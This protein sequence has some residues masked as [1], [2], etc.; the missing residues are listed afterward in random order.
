MNEKETRHW[1]A[2]IFK[3]AMKKILPGCIILVDTH[4]KLIYKPEITVL[5][6]DKY[7]MFEVIRRVKPTHTQI[8]KMFAYN[9]WGE[10]LATFV[11]PET[12]EIQLNDIWL[13]FLDRK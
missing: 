4:S 3:P 9:K 2:T 10:A 13:H 8:K 6:K 11:K 5:Y 7:A 12:F 1:I